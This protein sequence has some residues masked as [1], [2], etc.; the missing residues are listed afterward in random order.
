MSDSRYECDA[1]LDLTD[2]VRARDFLP[3]AAD[4]VYLGLGQRPSLEQGGVLD[5]ALGVGGTDHSRVHARQAQCETQGDARRSIGARVVAALAA[6]ELVVE[7]L[8]A[9]PILLVVAAVGLL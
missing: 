8:H 7:L 2:P 4:R 6:A 5:E 9:A 3:A 1:V